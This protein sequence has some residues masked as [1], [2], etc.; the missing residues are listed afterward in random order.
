MKDSIRFISEKLTYII[1]NEWTICVEDSK[2]HYQDGV[3]VHLPC[4]S[5]LAEF[6]PFLL[7]SLSLVDVI[8][9]FVPQSQCISF[10][11]APLILL[12]CQ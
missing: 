7:F 8:L 9:G 5:N 12:G 2:Y 1:T 10:M 11:Y 6:L 4:F 3:L